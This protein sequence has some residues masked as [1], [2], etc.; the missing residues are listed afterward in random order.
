[1]SG[2]VAE[3][4]VW[5]VQRLSSFLDVH[6]NTIR[7]WIHAGQLPA[8]QLPGGEWRIADSA[9]QQLQVRGDE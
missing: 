1:M 7:R 8:F 2:A 3:Q 6:H 4:P 5:T 9:V